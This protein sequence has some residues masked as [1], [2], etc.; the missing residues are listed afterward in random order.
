M[1]LFPRACVS[2]ASIGHVCF[3]PFS[4][5]SL[6]FSAKSKFGPQE[7][8]VKSRLGNLS[9]RVF[10]IKI[11]LPRK[12]AGQ[13]T[14]TNA[15]EREESLDVYGRYTAGDISGDARYLFS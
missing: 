13:K 1:H 10:I 9:R 15:R 7:R 3:A 14:H 2:V 5:H 4:P 11:Y 8:V 12:G 6:S